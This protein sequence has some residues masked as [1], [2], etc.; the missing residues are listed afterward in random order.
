MAAK[1]PDGEIYINLFK[2]M[3]DEIAASSTE[4]LLNGARDLLADRDVK[5]YLEYKKIQPYVYLSGL[6]NLLG[7]EMSRENM[8]RILKA[9]GIEPDSKMMTTLLKANDENGVAY[10]YAVYFLV[11]L[12]K[13]PN[14]KNVCDL[15]GALGLKPNQALA[16]KE[17]DLYNSR[18]SKK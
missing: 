5:E 8:A 18:Y 16:R 14:V 17:L 13:E 11:I 3:L 7:R 6:L 15:I 12:G 2:G 10:V 9:V 4:V 1:D